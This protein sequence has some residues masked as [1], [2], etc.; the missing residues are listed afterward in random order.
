VNITD[1]EAPLDIIAKTCGC[2]KDRRSKKIT[3]SIVVQYH[4]VCL[5]KIDIIVAELAACEG[6]LRHTTDEVER[7]IVEIEIIQL[8]TIKNS[9]EEMSNNLYINDILEEGI[10]ANHHLKIQEMQKEFRNIVAHELRN[11]VTPI[12]GLAEILE[13][14]SL[15]NKN[16]K[17]ELKGQEFEI[18]IRSAK[19]LQLLATN[20]FDS[21]LLN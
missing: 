21:I 17:I 18:I 15:E 19:R 14:R 4:S 9:L 8:R 16:G 12:L 7:K 2:E 6:L 5:D 20:M 10:A 13:D 1:I 3:Y 11:S